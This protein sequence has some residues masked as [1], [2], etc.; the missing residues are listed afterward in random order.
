MDAIATQGLD[1]HRHSAAHFE[2]PARRRGLQLI[3]IDRPGRG[4]SDPVP[5]PCPPEA[6]ATKTKGAGEK[7]EGEQEGEGA[8]EPAADSQALLMSEATE[9]AVADTVKQVRISIG[10]LFGRGRS[11]VLANPSCTYGARVG[12]RGA[13]IR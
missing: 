10:R 12:E 9:A 8:A 13:S 7:G 6:D 11:V 2:E 1:S 5:T 4:F 3:C